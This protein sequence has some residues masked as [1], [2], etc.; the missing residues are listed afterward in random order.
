MRL[1]PHLLVALAILPGSLAVDLKKSAIVSFD[2]GTPQ[3]VVDAAMKSIV[4]AGG[5][6][7]HKYSLIKY[8]SLRSRWTYTYS[9]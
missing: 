2:D 9:C 6:I 7:T 3:S 4:A 1:S 8:A 5:K